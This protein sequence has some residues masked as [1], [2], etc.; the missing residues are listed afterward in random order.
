MPFTRLLRVSFLF[1]TLTLC[2]I[3]ISP[4]LLWA[5]APAPSA[6]D[7]ISA[8]PV[9]LLPADG[10]LT[11]GS[12]HPPL[13]IPD[14]SWQPVVGA[15]KYQVQISASSGFAAPLVST[16][17][18]NT[19]YTPLI[20][21]GDGL[22]YWRVR[23][24]VSNSWQDYSDPFG[25]QVDWSDNQTLLP[26]LLSPAQNAVRSAFGPHDFSWMPLPGAA[27][28]QFQIATDAGM[29]TVVYSAVAAV[30]NHTPPQRFDNNVYYWRVTPLNNQGRAGAPSP[31]WSFTFN[32]S[33]APQLLTPA[34]AAELPFVPRFSWTAVDAA[35]EYRLQVSTQENFVTFD[36]VVVT[37]NTD[38]TP[39]KAY[40]NDQDFFWRVQAVDARG[41][42]S[43]W[44]EIRRFRAKWNF[45]PQLFAPANSSVG[46]SYPFFSW[47]PVP[48]A[49]KYQIQIA[50]NNAFNPKI[51]DTTLY[52][53][54][55]YTQPEWSTALAN[56]AY[57]WQVRAVDAQGS[58]T[59]WSDAWSFQYVDPTGVLSPGNPG[60]TA[61][62][63]IYPLPYYTPDAQNLPV[64]GDRSFPWPLFL[65]D[66]AHA[67]RPLPGSPNNVVGPDYY[68]LQVD[69]DPGFFSPNFSVET[70]GIA[71]APT[72]N[73][74][75]ADLQEGTL[76]YWRVQAYREG[77]PMG[78]QPTWT[79]RHSSAV[80]SL[81]MSDQ[82]DP[83][84][85]VDGFEV[86]GSPP[87]LGWL[88]VAGADHYELHLARDKDFTQLV[89]QV[90][91]QFVN[92]VPWQEQLDAMPFG[93]YWW[94]VRAQDVDDKPLGEWGPA[95]HF[96]LSLDVTIGNPYDFPVPAN[97]A[98]DSTGRSWVAGSPDAGAG[99]HEL[100]DL[101]LIVDRRV[102]DNYNQH[103]VIAFTT[104]AT[105]SDTVRYA[106]YFDTDHIANSGAA[107]DPR[108]NT[109]ISPSPL[110]R[111]E[112]VLYVDKIG[113]GL[114]SADFYVWNGSSW[115]PKQDLAAM[116]GRI[117]FDEALQSIQILLPYTA[118]GSADT[119]WVGSLALAVFSLEA[120]TIRDAIPAQ[121]ASLDNPVFVSNMLNPLFP[122]DT[123]FSNPIVYE[124]MPPL[125]WRMS[126]FTTD[127]YQV[128]V[129]R[130]AQFTDIVETWETFES[131]TSAIFTL[132]PT[133][134][135]SQ[136]AYANNE[137]YY[138]R[139]RPRH[140]R[141]QATTFDYGPWSPAMRF[142]LDSRRVGNPHLST[143]V[144]AFMTPTFAW[145]RV[146]GAAGYTI[147]I[148][149]DSNFSTPFLTQDTDAT[150]FT[151]SDNGSL[152]PGTQYYWR[153]VMRRSKDI[154]GHWT[155]TLSFIKTS[156]WPTPIAPLA[157]SILGQ[158]PTLRWSAVLTPTATPR[159]AAPS[160]SLQIANNLAFNQPRIT[161][162]TQSTAFS[163]V[164]GQNL[165]NGVWYWRVAL[166]DGNNKIGPYSPAL[167]F[168]TGY[169]LPTLLWPPQDAVIDTLPT[170]AWEPIDGAA[171][172]KIEYANNSSFNGST[173]VTTDLTRFTPT[174]AL[175]YSTYFWRIQMI[176][177]DGNPGPL[178]GQKFYYYLPASFTVSPSTGIAPTTVTFTDT[179]TGA[180]QSRLWRFGDGSSSTDATPAHRYTT[181]GVF[182]V[183]LQNTTVDGYYREI[184]QVNAVRI[185]QVVKAIFTASPTSG[186][187]PLQITF[188]DTSTGDINEWL[189]N[190]GDGNTD[191]RRHPQHTYQQTGVYNVIL[192]VSGP[193]GADTVVRQNLIA[194]YT[195]TPTPTPTNTPTAT[196]TPTATKT[197]TATPTHTATA[198]PT[199]TP[200]ATPTHTPT[201]TPTSTPT[202]TPTHTPIATPTS[203]PTATPTHT[204]TATPTAT[205]TPSPTPDVEIPWIGNV[206]PASHRNS[207]P[208]IITVE[209]ANFVKTPQLFLGDY[210]ALDVRF[211]TK[212]QLVAV[213]PSGMAPG[214][215]DI[216]VCNPNQKCGV[217][218]KSFTVID[219][220]S[221]V[222]SLY[223]PALV[224]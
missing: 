175:P 140:E 46:L 89:E 144:D 83:I 95:R 183:T 80:P 161:Q 54:T 172:Y 114:I 115:M 78:S 8:I 149:D 107:T 157:D 4:P 192:S 42:T 122:F 74:P 224:R 135:Q 31:V 25:F 174:K 188:Q 2:L 123:P 205:N 155:E 111:P 217:L 173:T 11:T 82:P 88:P 198:T 162:P 199:S 12:S 52:N 7:A 97:L 131:G 211:M 127:G 216:R 32:W 218:P 108:G 47:A 72:L 201:A 171:K 96:N 220:A 146:D 41:I 14:L 206:D 177:A 138:W 202:A 43:P 142:K 49:E 124:D 64:H 168:T 141:H 197:P 182:T 102:D 76:Y 93:T 185:Y 119:D 219:P 24:F 187:Y 16:E 221:Q 121:G 120:N 56:T 134:F 117:G 179:S 186:A 104:G 130:D 158:Q 169:T 125:H 38:Y 147:Q 118:L 152:L 67:P 33:S 63:L 154:I 23:A 213:T 176:D 94:R 109:A 113:N 28:Y 189:W 91:P 65:W 45:K 68:L 132:L 207:S 126:P 145:D 69:D 66:S 196:V 48:G 6:V 167:G 9:L 208:I 44:S 103:W 112:Y 22:Y 20:A 150:S 195:P 35:K 156:L 81:P 19:S 181:S 73:H 139:V 21:L 98:A 148:D 210:Q 53:V 59:P 215:Y 204:P 214:V 58:V 193:G 159:L 71:A 39:V 27:T 40:S 184:L 190:F 106:L 160:Y 151:P 15:T 26:L 17:T 128:Q 165:P 62:N 86:V 164:K 13:G 5:Q 191:T 57:Y 51:V 37:R 194:V 50:N 85:P 79:A 77:L 110:Y 105:I 166:V 101:H 92:Y 87:I 170:F 75:F 153:V 129:A 90:R 18:V 116:N 137:S 70:R 222:Y 136:E 55:Q 223:L 84:Y 180:V 61:P 60:P 10:A 200:T 29:S 1:F 34:Q 30:P 163:P 209:G 143:G 203:T 212:S 36:Q 99:S 3:T 178:A 100:R 133:T